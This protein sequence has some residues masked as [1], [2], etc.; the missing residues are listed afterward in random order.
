MT[1]TLEKLFAECGI[2]PDDLSEMLAEAA[3][4]L[5]D[6]GA[7]FDCGSDEYMGKLKKLLWRLSE[8]VKEIYPDEVEFHKN[9]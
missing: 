6:A 8:I 9:T 1:D 3:E 4:A 2:P 7:Q 5:H